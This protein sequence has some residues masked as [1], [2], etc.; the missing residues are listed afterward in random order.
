MEYRSK[1]LK[2]FCRIF[3]LLE[4]LFSTDGT[5]GLKAK[6]KFELNGLFE[7]SGAV[8]ITLAKNKIRC[9]RDCETKEECLSVFYNF[10]S[11]ECVMHNKQFESSSFPVPSGTGAAWRYYVTKDVTGICSPE[12]L[13]YRPLQFCYSVHEMASIDFTL[14]NDFCIARGG[15]LSAVTSQEMND[16]L[17]DFLADRP[18]NRV[19][20]AGRK[21]P[22]GSWELDDGTAMSYFNWYPGQPEGPTHKCIV[23]KD[24]SHGNKWADR[25]CLLSIDPSRNTYNCSFVCEY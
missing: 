18:H 5:V 17:T 23:M 21:Q 12:H 20:I 1:T 8:G 25:Q 2:I 14:I 24:L 10:D 15:K 7:K 22:N 13:Y 9:I 16:Y 6:L 3:I 11:Q 4:I 19:C